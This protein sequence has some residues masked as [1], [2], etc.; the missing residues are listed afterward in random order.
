MNITLQWIDVIIFIGICQG[1]FLS[2]T[3]Q[4]ISHNNQNANR[5]LS[6]LIALATVMLVGRFVYFRFLTEWVFQ[7]S[8]LV[9]AIVFLFGPFTYMYIKRLLFRENHRFWLS[10]IHFVPFFGLV[11]FALF[12]IIKYTPEAYYQFFLNGNL[13]LYFRIISVLMIALNTLYVFKSF[14]LLSVFKKAEKEVFSFQQTPVTY[15]N[16]FLLSVSVCLLA[17]AVSL[18]DSVVFQNRIPYID[19]D[20]IWVAIPV[21]IYVIGYFSLRQ[22]ELFRITEAPPKNSFKKERLP[23]TEA[24]LLQQ[25]LNSLM[26]NEKIFLQSDLTLADVAEMLQT[27][28]NNVS[29]LLNQVYKTTFYDFINQ[30]RVKEFVKKVEN[31]EHLKHTILALSMD[32]GFNSKSTF[33]KAFKDTMQD[34]PSNYIKKHRAA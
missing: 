1:I 23:E 19:Y 31:Q 5:I 34:T 16:F 29:W 27:S 8:I 33:N 30:Y 13:L 11:V 4:R 25:K 6:Y 15:L 17:W 26:T 28:T 12:Y 20:S 3:L 18:T 22:P 7:W 21:F 9:D 24:L 32:V 10:K 14:Q 2:L